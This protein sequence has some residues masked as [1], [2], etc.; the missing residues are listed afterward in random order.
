[1]DAHRLGNTIRTLRIRVGWTQRELA[2]RSSTSPATVSRIERG[3]ADRMPLG[4]VH[5]VGLALDAWVDFA[6][7][8]RGGD[9]DRA[10]NARHAGMHEAIAKWFGRLSA[11]TLSPE[12]SFSIYGERGIVDALAWHAQS[13]TLLVIELKTELVDIS[14][15]LGTLDRKLRLAPEIARGRGWIPRVVAGWLLV[16]DGRTNHRRLAANHAVLRARLPDDGR[17]V[18]GWLHAPSGPLMAI[19]FL[20]NHRVE[21]HRTTLAAVKRVRRRGHARPVREKPAEQSL[22]EQEVGKLRGHRS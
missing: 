15:L 4:S 17:R 9:L 6:I 14:D 2:R 22:Y 21:G 10:L 16:A 3:L 1:M 12:V 18:R 13:E 5:E 19:S 11:W 7:R 20:P 8:W